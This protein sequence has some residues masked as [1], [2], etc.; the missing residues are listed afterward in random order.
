MNVIRVTTICYLENIF[1]EWSII[2]VSFYKKYIVARILEQEHNIIYIN[3]IPP[4][5]LTSYVCFLTN[6]K[7]CPPQ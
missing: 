6:F 2:Q 3:G 4:S 5:P 1:I 7:L